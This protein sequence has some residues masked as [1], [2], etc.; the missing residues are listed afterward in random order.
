MGAR[1][2]VVRGLLLGAA[3]ATLAVGCGYQPLGASDPTRGGLRVAIEPITNETFRPGIQGAVAGALLRQLRLWGILRSPEAGP[4][5]LILSGSVTAYQNEPIAFDT[6]DIGQRFR[7]RVT[8]SATL[9]GRTDGKVRLREPVV[10]EAFYTAG[11]GAAGARI[12]EDDALQRAAQD[13][14]SKLVAR[15]MEEW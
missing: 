8:V 14:A 11:T 7:V 13:V 12:A 1:W 3:A 5:D 15:L 6:Q 9:V 2:S 4:P 10:G